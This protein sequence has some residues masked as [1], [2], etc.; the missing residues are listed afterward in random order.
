LSNVVDD[1][2]ARDVLLL[3]KEDGL[4][5]TLIAGSH[6][7]EL[8]ADAENASREIHE[9]LNRA[10]WDDSIEYVEP[11][12]WLS[13]QADNQ[14]TADTTDAEIEDMPNAD[15]ARVRSMGVT[16][17]ESIHSFRQEYVRDMRGSGRE[18]G[19]NMT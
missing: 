14:M 7:I 17:I 6:C 10:F 13:Q 9:I 4:S 19:T 18:C 5:S 8:T 1:V 3:E 16:L 2:D 11:W 15:V 12:A